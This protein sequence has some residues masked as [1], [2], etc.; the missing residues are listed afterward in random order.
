LTPEVDRFIVNHLCQFAA[1]LVR[2]F[3]AE[4]YYTLREPSVCR[5]LTLLHSTQR[6]GL[7]GNI[8]AP[9]NSLWT[10]PVCIKILEKNSN[11]L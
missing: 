7:F 8:F 9:S 11:G 10:W 4:R 3:L 2:S 6:F 1:E 5:I